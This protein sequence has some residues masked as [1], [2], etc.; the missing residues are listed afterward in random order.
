M[1][2]LFVG[3][4]VI[5][6]RDA[7]A[8]V[9]KACFLLLVPLAIFHANRVA[10][11]L[12]FF[13]LT[14]QGIVSH[15]LFRQRSLRYNA[16]RRVEFSRWTGD[17]VVR[18][19]WTRLAIPSNTHAFGDLRFALLTAV[20]AHHGPDEYEGIIEHQMQAQPHRVYRLK[21]SFAERA[22]AAYAVFA[23]LVWAGGLSWAAGTG[24]PILVLAGAM[25]AAMSFH[26][27]RHV[28]NWYE[29][30]SDGL[31][32]HS[33]LRRQFLP[34]GD[35]LTSMVGQDAQGHAL[36]L[37][38]IHRTVRIRTGWRLPAEELVALLNQRWTMPAT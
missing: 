33:L 30:R 3:G 21:P 27:L 18:G 8:L 29:L 12:Q 20:W 9:A 7:L 25:Q 15:G 10:A 13:E 22:Q 35:F 11:S 26:S 16:I 1:L 34:A 6:E 19:S 5:G 28:L 24:W 38:F 23:P 17:L 2:V 14:P 32:I 4:F 37:A 36:D 31:V